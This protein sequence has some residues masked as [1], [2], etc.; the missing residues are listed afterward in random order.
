MENITKVIVD[1]FLQNNTLDFNSTHK[2]LSLPIINRI[3]KKM[4]HG[5][6]FE[7]IKVSDNLIIDGHHR[8]ISSVLAGFSIGKIEYH[9]TSA[10]IEYKWKD[11]EF[12]NE[13]WDTEFKIKHLNHLDAEYNNISIE[14]IIDIIR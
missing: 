3:F 12:I 2:K 7:D 11:V 5:I 9:K 4:K 14:K 10:K 1:D 13:D 8:Y 6:R